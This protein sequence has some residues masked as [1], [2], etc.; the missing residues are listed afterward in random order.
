MPATAENDDMTELD[1]R[2]RR[3]LFRANHRGTKEAD[4]MIGGFATRNMAGLSDLELEQLEAAL[5]HGDVDL[6]D[7]L[8]GRYPVPPEHANPMLDRLIRECAESGAGLPAHLRPI[9]EG[10]AET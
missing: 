4:L 1:S 2:R 6:A 5:D 10:P 3:L 7:W 8:S 9:P